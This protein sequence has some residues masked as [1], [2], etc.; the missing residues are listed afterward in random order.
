[1]LDD[2]FARGYNGNEGGDFHRRLVRTIHTASMDMP[3]VEIDDQL[4]KPS[5]TPQYRRFMLAFRDIT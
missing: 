2:I 1:M 4:G 3:E 5:E